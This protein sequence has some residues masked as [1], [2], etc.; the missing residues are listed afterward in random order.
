MA[1]SGV[2]GKRGEDHNNHWG[3]GAVG[4]SISSLL[5][6]QLPFLAV[7]VGKVPGFFLPFTT[8]LLLSFRRGGGKSGVIVPHSSARSGEQ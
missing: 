8:Y 7:V 3:S 5:V 6:C 4:A 2:E 1:L